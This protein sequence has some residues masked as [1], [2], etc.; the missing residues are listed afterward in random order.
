[1]ESL[2]WILIA[3]AMSSLIGFALA[4]LFWLLLL[5]AVGLT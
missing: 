2:L 4:V 1:M 5:V 3:L